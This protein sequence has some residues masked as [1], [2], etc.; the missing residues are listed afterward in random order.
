MAT[1]GPV[2]GRRCAV[3]LVDRDRWIQDAVAS[4][5][6]PVGETFLRVLKLPLRQ[7]GSMKY[8]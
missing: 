4:L 5:P 8:S 6:G 3:S 1:L 2:F 7:D